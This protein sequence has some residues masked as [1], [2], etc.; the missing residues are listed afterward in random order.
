LRRRIPGIGGDMPPRVSRRAGESMIPSART[1]PAESDF[2]RLMKEPF[3]P[4]E[5]DSDFEKLLK[6]PLRRLGRVLGPVGGI[7]G[8]ALPES[9][10][11]GEL[12]PEERRRIERLPG[13]PS[14]PP[15]ETQ[16]TERT[17]RPDP[18]SRPPRP[19]EEPIEEI[20]VEGRTERLPRERQRMQRPAVA[21]V[22]G[23]AGLAGLALLL[24]R[25]SSRP[26]STAP[27]P[28]RYQQRGDD[29]GIREDLD[30]S[31]S[32]PAL[33]LPIP[34]SERDTEPETA[35]RPA[36]SAPETATRPADLPTLLPQPEPKPE[37]KPQP[38]T[39][40][41]PPALGFCPPCDPKAVSSRRKKQREEKRKACR[42]FIS[43]R[44]PAHKRKMCVSD[45]T[46]YLLGKLKRTVK[47]KVRKRI[48]E[49]LEQ[50]GVPA[51]KL[52]KLTK[53]P[54]KPKA[55]VEVGGVEIDIKDLL[56]GS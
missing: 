17:T 51:E 49:E 41:K 52:L 34:V 48:V 45:F 40:V 10:G 38:L 3:R 5:P 13:G 22:A 6:K 56:E 46:K 9:L 18:R 20:V 26:T 30:F 12:S 42:A 54:R 23:L 7:I 28:R 36:E 33:P 50:R 39:D 31:P 8:A 27:A 24:R 11:S 1:P 4:R 21:A 43:V 25:R 35:P 32:L 15:A 14:A 44:V 53:R 2:E 29:L 19:D 37:P 47:S 16:T 55:E